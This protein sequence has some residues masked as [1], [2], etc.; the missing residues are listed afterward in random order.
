MKID[1]R[2]FSGEI[3][4]KA[5]QELPVGA[6]QTA[7]NARL[8]S[9]DLEAWRNMA[10]V[11]SLPKYSGGD[12]VVTVFPLDIDLSDGGPYW[13]HW[14]QSEL[15]AWADAVSV[16]RAL[17]LGNDQERFYFSGVGGGGPQLSNLWMATYPGD[18]SDDVAKY[19]PPPFAAHSPDDGK[20][21]YRSLG[22]GVDGPTVPPIAKPYN[23]AD[24]EEDAFVDNNGGEDVVDAGTD[25]TPTYWTTFLGPGDDGT[26]STRVTSNPAPF[27]AFAGTRSF[28]GDNTGADTQTQAYQDISNAELKILAGGTYTLTW[29]QASG[30]DAGHAQ[31]RVEFLDKDGN[32]ISEDAAPLTNNLTP[33]AWEQRTL[34]GTI[35]NATKT[36]RIWQKYAKDAGGTTADAFID[37]I[38]LQTEAVDFFDDGS[39]LSFWE[40]AL[41]PLSPGAPQSETPKIESKNAVNR[42]PVTAAFYDDPPPSASGNPVYMVSLWHQWQKGTLYRNFSLNDSLKTT[43]SFL[44]DNGSPVGNGNRTALA[45]HIGSDHRGTGEFLYFDERKLARRFGSDWID[46][47]VDSKVYPSP[48]FNGTIDEA[49]FTRID[50]TVEPDNEGFATVTFKATDMRS[51]QVWASITD[52]EFPL[53]G[54]YFGLGVVNNN[55][56]PDFT[57][58]GMLDD[59][60]VRVT[61]RDVT[62]GVGADDTEST[63]T[64]SKKTRYLYT[65]SKPDGSESR[66]SPESTTVDMLLSGSIEVTTPT[67]ATDP[68]VTKKRI[69]RAATKQG[70]TDYYF[71]AETDLSQASYIDSKSDD[72]LGEKLQTDTYV[73]PPN[74]M[75]GLITAANGITFGFVGNQVCPSPINQPYAFPVEYRHATD[76]PVVALAAIDTDVY[77]L[78]QSFPYVV[79]GSSPETLVMPK[80]EKPQGCVSPRSVAVLDGV[81][82]LYASPDGLTAI[83]RAGVTVASKGLF[84]RKQWQ[85]LKPESIH[86][87]THDGRYYFWYDDGVTKA[88]YI[89]DPAPEGFGLIQL[90]FWCSA[91][92]SNP[93]DDVLYIVQS[94]VLKAWDAPGQSPLPYTWRSGLAQVPHPMAFGACQVRAADYSDITLRIFVDDKPGHVFQRA[95]TGPMEF[96]LPDAVFANENVAIELAGTSRVRRVEIAESMDELS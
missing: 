55:D 50:V 46:V 90:D 95:I 23:A 85:A 70:S 25:D 14:T 41:S 60:S 54:G 43:I 29:Q 48:S 34:S 69:Y 37:E 22:L 26:L 82:V 73:P 12:D 6:A 77:V 8:L 9:G 68:E 18:S 80:L 81:G 35:P 61:A 92:F 40:Q 27:T 47:G 2:N 59:I 36:T 83:S 66:G 84:T 53:Y 62:G 72:Q 78:T 88:G 91:A 39:N 51:G 67:S 45:V 63:P 11:Q 13:M 20:Y 17:V 24:G 96:P 94:G 56:D 33:Y 7:K 42:H 1:I 58:I 79:V 5:P 10:T 65:F 75:R 31:M 38:R 76:Y 57:D 52:T 21:P 30:A 28:Y 86:A 64:G 44:W 74:E 3:P 93:I 32:Q 87:V 71:V 15:S 19:E 4:R 16:A 89:L 49:Y